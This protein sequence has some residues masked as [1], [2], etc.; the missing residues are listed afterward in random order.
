[1]LWSDTDCIIAD[2][3]GIL[4][5]IS[6]VCPLSNFTKGVFSEIR[7]GTHSLV[8]KPGMSRY[9]LNVLETSFK[10]FAMIVSF[11]KINCAKIQNTFQKVEI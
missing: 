3:K 11:F 10:N 8:V 1:M 9:S 5:D 6:G 4:M 7:L 2:T